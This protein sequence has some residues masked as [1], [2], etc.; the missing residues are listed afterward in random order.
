[1]VTNKQIYRYLVA[2]LLISF[3]LISAFL[4]I[5]P[6]FYSIVFGLILGYVFNPLNK[7]LLNIIKNKSL[8]AL[9]TCLIII[10]VLLIILWFSIPLL[11]VQIFDSYVKFQSWEIDPVIDSVITPIFN[12]PQITGS[13]ISM[14]NSF[15][16]NSA[17]LF[18]NKLT[19]IIV[20]IPSLTLQL[21]VV[22]VVFFYILRDGDKA[23]KIIEETMPFEKN[24]TRRF[25]KKSKEVTFSVIYG[26]FVIGIV[27]GL[28]TGVGFYFAGVEN[29]TLLTLLAI[30]AAVIPIIGPWLVWVPVVLM[31]FL[32]GKTLAAILLAIYSAVFVSFFI[33]NLLT[34]AFISKRA[35]LP[36]SLMLIGVIGGLFCFGIM[37]I[38]LGP[39]I[40]AYFVVLYEIY[41]EYNAK[42][43]D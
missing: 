9:I 35:N 14:Y 17:Q 25:I 34:I 4:I 2:A 22:L 36:N 16:S 37:G 23:L 41:I 27:T 3:L 10:T 15:I 39:L 31:L 5:R 38:F 6:I 28:A 19:D 13:F 24:T 43:I 32:T 8:T 11:A 1:M 30:L 29:V 18:L 40:I 33:D 7:R 26:R 12:S 20:N 21:L 42:N